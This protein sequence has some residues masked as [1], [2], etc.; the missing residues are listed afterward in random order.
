MN[1]TDEEATAHI[2]KIMPFCD[3]LGLS[4]VSATPERVEATAE[5]AAKQAA[6]NKWFSKVWDHQQAYVKLFAN[7]HRYR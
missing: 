3:V 6:S 2:R 5:W 4:V 1:P 7:A